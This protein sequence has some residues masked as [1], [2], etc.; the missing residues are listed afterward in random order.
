ML[1]EIPN[2]EY[3]LVQ[4]IKTNDS[5]N[6]ELA[7]G[8]AAANNIALTWYRQLYEWLRKIGKIGVG[9]RNQEKMIARLLSIVELNYNHQ[10]LT[11]IPPCIAGLHNL[12]ALRLYSNELSLVPSSIGELTALK[13]LILTANKLCELPHSIGQL[14]N[15]EELW[16]GFNQLQSLPVSLGQLNQLSSVYLQHNQLKEIEESLFKNSSIHTFFIFGNPL[17]KGLEYYQKAYSHCQFSN[18][19][20]A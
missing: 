19:Y 15:L 14:G 9:Y 13:T 7:L 8:L 1:K 16:L 6:I 3:A 11:Q 17:T 10:K 18:N 5:N 4:L 2:Q 20:P 12:T